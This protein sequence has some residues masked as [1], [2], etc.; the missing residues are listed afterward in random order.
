MKKKLFVSIMLVLVLTL[1]FSTS[2]ALADKP[3]KTVSE[4][5][6]LY[7]G[8]TV[9]RSGEPFHITHG[10]VSGY[11]LDEPIGNAFALSKMTLEVNGIELEPDYVTSEWGALPEYGFK[12]FF[13]YFTFNFP[14]GMTGEVTFVRR[15]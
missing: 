11:L 6:S 13:K 9:W 2:V 14:E 15:Y 7:N 12:Y 10:F 3:P 4:Q 5:L 8:P 1:A